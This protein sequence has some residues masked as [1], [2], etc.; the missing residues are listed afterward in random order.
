MSKIEG[1]IDVRGPNPIYFVGYRAYLLPLQPRGIT[2]AQA[3]VFLGLDQ[4]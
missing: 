4:A 1:Y 3:R 2:V